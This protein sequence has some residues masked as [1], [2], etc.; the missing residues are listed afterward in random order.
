MEARNALYEAAIEH[1]CFPTKES[2]RPGVEMYIKSATQERRSNQFT[3]YA[4]YI[5]LHYLLA[6]ERNTIYRGVLP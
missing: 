2:G 1:H 3:T 5:Q 6:S 4:I